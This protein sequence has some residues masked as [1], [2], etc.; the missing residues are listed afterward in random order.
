MMLMIETANY[1]S[2]LSNYF[3][4]VSTFDGVF[5]LYGIAAVID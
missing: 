3:Y 4:L 1:C 2:I 5:K